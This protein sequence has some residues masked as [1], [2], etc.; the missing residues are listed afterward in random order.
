MVCLCY[1]FMQKEHPFMLIKITYIFKTIKIS[2]CRK[3]FAFKLLKIFL[4]QILE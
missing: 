2:V 1:Q 3:Q 4:T